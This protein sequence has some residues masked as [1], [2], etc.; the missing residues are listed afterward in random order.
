MYQEPNEKNGEN[1]TTIHQTH[2][3][4]V[5]YSVYSKT[6]AIIISF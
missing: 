5:C 4:V 2:T 3:R 1:H 6:K